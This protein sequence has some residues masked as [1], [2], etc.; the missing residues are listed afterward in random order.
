M[1]L[2]C[3]IISEKCEVQYVGSTSDEFKVRFR[4]HKTALLTNKTAYE[5]AVHYNR[6]EQQISDFEFVVIKKVVNESD[7][8]TD[9]RLLTREAF[10]CSQLC[11]L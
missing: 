1:C 9:K 7:G 6:I 3:G 5:L 10:W 2:I 4:N 11:T 8:Q